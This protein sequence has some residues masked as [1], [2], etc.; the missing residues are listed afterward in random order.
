MRSTSSTDRQAFLRLRRPRPWPS[1]GGRWW[2]AP[3]RRRACCNNNAWCGVV[4]G[5][6]L[7][8]LVVPANVGS[9]CCIHRPR[10]D[11]YIKV[12]PVE[13]RHHHHPTP[14]PSG[15]YVPEHV[16]AARHGLLTRAALPD[17]HH[18][19]LHVVLRGRQ[20]MEQGNGSCEHFDSGRAN[21]NFPSQRL[22]PPKGATPFIQATV[23]NHS[24]F[25]HWPKP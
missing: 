14:S 11:L 23:L 16:G 25:K 4:W 22:K 8:E 10:H 19:A 24:T 13:A 2:S 17:A 7:D 6:G 9:S 12:V 21:S 1:A 5:F 3:A 15:S 20:V 18:L